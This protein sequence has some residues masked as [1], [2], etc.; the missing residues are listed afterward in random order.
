MTFE[1]VIGEHG[2]QLTASPIGP[3]SP[4]IPGGPGKP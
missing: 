4:V 3:P 2:Y 1:S